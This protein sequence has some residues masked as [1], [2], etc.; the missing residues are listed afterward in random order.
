MRKDDG[1]RSPPPGPFARHPS[2]NQGRGEV[3]Q[4]GDNLAPAL[5]HHH[6]G[7]H[8][9]DQH[10]GHH[11]FCHHHHSQLADLPQS[12]NELPK[13]TPEKGLAYHCTLTP[14]LPWHFE[15][16]VEK[17]DERV[18]VGFLIGKG[19]ISIHRWIYQIEGLPTSH[20]PQKRKGGGFSFQR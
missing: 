11:H 19:L 13:M 7:H 15:D 8:H 10:I 1:H 9:L 17:V 4:E 3:K 16:S 18:K 14:T 20:C 5:G 2:L 12:L 6:L